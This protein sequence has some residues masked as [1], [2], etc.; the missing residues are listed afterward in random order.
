MKA[1]QKLGFRI[2]GDVGVVGFS[3]GIFSEI[4][5]PPLTTVDQHGYEMGALATRMLL[6]RIRQAGEGPPPSTK[7]IAGNLIIRESSGIRPI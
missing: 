7:V 1:L 3:N 6:N 5:D 4:S 2:P